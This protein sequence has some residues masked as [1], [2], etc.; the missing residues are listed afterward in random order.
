MRKAACL[1]FV[2]LVAFA[3]VWLQLLHRPGLRLRPRRSLRYNRPVERVS[4][5]HSDR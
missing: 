2:A 5:V 1:F 3:A 4:G